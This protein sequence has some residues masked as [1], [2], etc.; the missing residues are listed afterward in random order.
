M[1]ARVSCSEVYF[2]VESL[3]TGLIPGP[4]R[5]HI[6]CGARDQASYEPG[7]LTP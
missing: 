1:F 4:L 2:A 3:L 6:S 7:C 5:W